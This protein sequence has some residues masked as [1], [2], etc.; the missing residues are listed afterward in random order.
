MNAGRDVERLIAS[1]LAEEAAPG[2]PDRV[3]DSTRRVVSRT[4]QRRFAALWREHMLIS[5]ARLAAVAAV[6][7]MAVIGGAWIGRTMAPSGGGTPTA[8]PAPTAATQGDDPVAAYRSARDSICSTFTAQLDP[9]KGLLD[10]LYDPTLPAA[11]RV[12]RIG[13][14][15]S[16][17][18]GADAM[19]VALD[20]LAVPTALVADNAANLTR[21]RDVVG[22]VYR[23]WFLIGPSP[24]AGRAEELG[25]G[26]TRFWT[27]VRGD[28]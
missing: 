22:L 6:L 7:A 12:T 15:T 4:N 16:I 27:S 5:P 21:N 26:R 18:N 24:G 8:T 23:C 25:L 2:A 3:L 19:I 9:L 28:N 1:W 17:V 14:L 11:D 20:R 10:R 13:A